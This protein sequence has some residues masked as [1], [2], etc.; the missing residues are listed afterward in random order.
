MNTRPYPRTQP[1]FQLRNAM[2]LMAIAAAYPVAVQAAGTAGIAQ[3]AVGDVSIRRADGKTD[4]LVKG[5]EAVKVTDE[6]VQANP[7]KAVG[8][9]AEVV[10]GSDQPRSASA[11]PTA[12][13]T[14]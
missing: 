10:G 6:Y 7:W 14:S 11:S 4:A 8:V 1:Q 13:A 3:F 9:A 5:K 12:T 2:L